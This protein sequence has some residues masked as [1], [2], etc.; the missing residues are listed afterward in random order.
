MDHPVPSRSTIYRVLVRHQLVD[1]RPRRRRRDQYK[2][3]ERPVPMQLWQM[4]VM[5]S[6]WLVDGTEC[7]LVSGLDDHS[8]FCVI[9]DVV[10]RATGRAVCAAFTRA[11]AEYGCPEQVLTDN[12]RQFTGKFTWPR[13]PPGSIPCPT[14]SGS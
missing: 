1:A 11:L 9:A 3:W 10:R 4:D 7:K 5:G 6:V 2:R 12:G 14:R 8:R 13:P